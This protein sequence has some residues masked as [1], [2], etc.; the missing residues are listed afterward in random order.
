M[1]EEDK[2]L[3]Q[4]ATEL[5]SAVGTHSDKLQELIDAIND[6]NRRFKLAVA[7]ILLMIILL[8][9]V[10]ALAINARHTAHRAEVAVQVA[11]QSLAKAT[12]SLDKNKIT[13]IAGN[14]SRAGQIQLWDGFILPQLKVGATPNAIK[15]LDNAGNFIDNLF[16]PRTC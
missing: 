6:A 15:G 2:S 11:Q 14:D 1:D 7:G 5:G 16:K 12:A 8:V 10:G 3:S 4:A 9:G 13:C